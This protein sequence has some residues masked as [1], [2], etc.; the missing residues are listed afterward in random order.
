MEFCSLSRMMGDEPFL[1]LR[2]WLS[3]SWKK[4]KILSL[5]VIW[6]VSSREKE[7]WRNISGRQWLEISRTSTCHECQRSKP[8]GR[9]ARVPLKLLPQPT[10][11]N[12]RINVDGRKQK[13]ICHG[14][15][16]QLYEVSRAGS[17]DKQGSIED[18]KGDSLCCI[19]DPICP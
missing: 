16:R 9:L 18:S 6:A 12:H 2:G 5:E 15:H 4:L 10:N 19:R 17:V 3:R 11:P 1:H 13:E 7:Y 8:W 14:H